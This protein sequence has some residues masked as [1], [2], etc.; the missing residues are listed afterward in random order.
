[1]INDNNLNNLQPI[2]FSEIDSE[3]F[4]ANNIATKVHVKIDKNTYFLIN[5]FNEKKSK[6][7]ILHELNNRGLNIE[8]NELEDIINE[9]TK[10][11]LLSVSEVTFNSKSKGDYLKLSVTIFSEKT[12][13][14][15]SKF[16]KKLFL[17]NLM[18]VL[19]LVC[20]IISSFIIVDNFN[21]IYQDFTFSKLLSFSFSFLII[22]LL[23]DF[24]HEFGHTSAL[25]FFNQNCGRMGLGFYLFVPVLF[26]D[27]SNAWNLP[28]KKR[29]IVNSGGIYFEFIFITLLLTIY[30]I[31]KQ[32]ELFFIAC[33]ILMQVIFQFNPFIRTD[34]YWILSDILDIPN[35][36]QK[37]KLEIMKVF[38]KEQIKINKLL[39]FYGI[40]SY[41]ISFLIIMS[42]LLSK[43][44]VVN[45]IANFNKLVN[46]YQSDVWNVFEILIFFAS[47]LFYTLLL[48]EFIKLLSI[49]SQVVKN[50]FII[51]TILLI[52]P[53]TAFTQNVLL[54]K[55]KDKQN[56][57]IAYANIWTNNNRNGV[58]SNENG[59]FAIIFSTP[60][61]SIFVSHLG[62]K[63]KGIK[64]EAVK[65]I[66]I[67]LEENITELKEIIV[68]S[69][70]GVG[71]INKI[72]NNLDKNY[73]S[74]TTLNNAYFNYDVT[75]KNNT[76]GYFDGFISV[77]NSSYQ[78]TNFD[79]R[80]T[81]L[82]I[83]LNK[84]NDI[85]N[86]YSKSPKSILSIFF[87][88]ALPFIK[89]KD[90]YNFKIQKG[91]YNQSEIYSV[92]FKPKNADK[93]GQYEGIF[94]V[95]LK[96]YAILETTFELVSNPQ[97]KD[98]LI[99]IGFSKVKT[100]TSYNLE[101]YII[102]YK[103][104]NDTYYNNFIKYKSFVSFFD[105]KN[106]EKQDITIKSTFQTNTF[107]KNPNKEDLSTGQNFNLFSLKTKKGKSKPKKNSYL[108]LDLEEKI[109][110][111]KKENP[112]LND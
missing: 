93:K 18:V 80:L 67:I 56:L 86:F 34:G 83:N 59:D 12:I 6:K 13:N 50:R 7:E 108:N 15:I 36:K 87:P 106:K 28:K 23:I 14:S 107:N 9:F 97:N 55:I 45:I 39:F 21:I 84:Y 109:N 104:D 4:I 33:V 89:N 44:S 78:K 47:A 63:K 8:E 27:V 11:G 98:V 91:V 74:K 82:N 49:L 65:Q 110:K 101:E 111:L 43:N 54:G 22:Y 20:T 42:V 102:K 103:F 79:T 3:T 58:V 5:L 85:S 57:P 32:Y 25:K 76:L 61:D 31:T 64:I 90:D 60:Q 62:Y 71:L 112:E 73:P 48:K 88:T 1:M 16:F 35:L 10:I 29:L 96:S 66:D 105:S 19:V 94:I 70:D 75:T 51:S 41:L 100:T 68:L 40:S 72:I 30:S 99:E 46:S 95:D 77:I 24:I 69:L 52:A 26:V 17:P 81:E 38:R 2:T 92:N 53:F 37:S